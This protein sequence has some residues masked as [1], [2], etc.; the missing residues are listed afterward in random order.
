MLSIGAHIRPKTIT[1]GEEKNKLTPSAQHV[2]QMRR[3]VWVQA[4]VYKCV[5]IMVVTFLL[6]TVGSD[7]GTIELGASCFELA[8]LTANFSERACSITDWAVL[9]EVRAVIW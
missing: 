5:D 3:S 4:S 7:A 6:W 1:R 2:Q 9:K 8:N